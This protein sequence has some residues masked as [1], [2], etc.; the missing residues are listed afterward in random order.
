MKFVIFH[1][2]FGSPDANWFPQLKENLEHFGQEVIVP[3]FPIEDW[4]ELTKTG[5]DSKVNKQTLENW[6]AEFSKEIEAFKP[7][8][9]LCFVGHSLGP[10]F[11]LHLINKF[12]LQLDSAIFVSPFLDKLNGPWQIDKVNESFYKTD[13]DFLKLKKLIPVSY[14]LYSDND[15]YVKTQ[16]S[17]LFAKA[18]ESSVIFVKRA[19]HMNSEVNLNEFPLVLD[20]CLSRIDLSLY[21]RYLMHHQ[22][23]SAQGYIVKA[24]NTGVLK[25]RPEEVIEEG[26]FHFRNLSRIGFCT[27]FTRLSDFWDPTSEYMEAA[28]S[29]ARR[30]KDFTRVLIVDKAEDLH[31]TNLNKQV[32]LDLAAGIKI[33]VCRYADIRSITPEPDFGIWDED[34]VCIVRSTDGKVSEVELNNRHEA[35]TEA[36]EWKH[37]IL[38]LAKEIKNLQDLKK[39]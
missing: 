5:P 19:G 28:R 2:A 31:N 37:A 16:H 25:L 35:I 8:D 12:N 13:F 33:F 20:L 36:K 22:R 30:I 23:L 32:E 9:K 38:G 24:Q 27:L 1:G 34:Y 10:L 29:A 18:L 3:K 17:L 4:S 21:Q 6:L 15:P 7:T 11:I 26:K 39:L 14:V